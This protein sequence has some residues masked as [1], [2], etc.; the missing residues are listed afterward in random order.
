VKKIEKS[1]ELKLIEKVLIDE[2]SVFG[3]TFVNLYGF[4]WIKVSWEN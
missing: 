2:F 4:F 3:K 1:F